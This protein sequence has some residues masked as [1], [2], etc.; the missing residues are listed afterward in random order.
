MTV[1]ERNPILIQDYLLHEDMAHFNRERIPKRVVHA[2]GEDCCGTF[3]VTHGISKYTKAKLF[4]EIGKQTTVFIRFSQVGGEKEDVGSEKDSCGF[5]IKFYAEDDNW[6][7]VENN[8]PVF[9]I[10]NSN[11]FSYCIHT[12]KRDSKTNCKSP[13]MMLNFWCLNPE[14]LHQVIVLMSD[15]GRPISFRN[16]SSFGSHTFSMIKNNNM[17]NKIHN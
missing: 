17:L 2:K 8:T 5:V 13:T 1:G 14:S 4:S 9:F 10:K 15:R 16:M 7:L 11:K 3:T 6:D 12:Q